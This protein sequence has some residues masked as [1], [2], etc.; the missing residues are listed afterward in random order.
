MS[1]GSNFDFDIDANNDHGADDRGARAHG[2][3]VFSLTSPQKKGSHSLRGS[4]F[5][6]ESTFL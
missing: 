2:S 4:P 1:V 5:S 3:G 6:L